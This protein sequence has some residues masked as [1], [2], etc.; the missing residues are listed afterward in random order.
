MGSKVDHD[1]E[2][3]ESPQVSGG[4]SSRNWFT[5]KKRPQEIVGGELGEWQPMV[6]S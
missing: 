3:S 2:K 4:R 1:E 6:L 5:T